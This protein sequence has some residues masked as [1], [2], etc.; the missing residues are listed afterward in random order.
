MAD[1]NPARRRGRRGWP[2]LV[3]GTEAFY[4]EPGSLPEHF[5]PVSYGM[6]MT[7]TQVASARPAG[8]TALDAFEPEAAGGKLDL[9][10]PNVFELDAESFIIPMAACLRGADNPVELLSGEVWRH[11]L[12]P[13]STDITFP[14]RWFEERMIDDG[15]PTLFTDLRPQ[16]VVINFTENAQVTAT[17]TQQAERASVHVLPVETVGGATVGGYQVYLIG[18]PRYDLRDVDAAADTL[19]IHLQVVS[20]DATTITVLAKIGDAS[21]FG[22]TESIIPITAPV[23]GR[24]PTTGELVDSNGSGGLGSGD[25]PLLAYAVVATPAA[26]EAGDEHRADY[27]RPEWVHAPSTSPI[28]RASGA[29]ILLPDRAGNLTDTACV[30]SGSVTITP[31][32]RVVPCAPG[33]WR[34]TARAGRLSVAWQIT[35]EW[36]TIIRDHYRT[37]PPSGQRFGVEVDLQSVGEIATGFRSRV[38][39][40]SRNLVITGP[41]KAVSGDDDR[42]QQWSATAHEASADPDGYVAPVVIEV[43]NT[44]ATLPAPAA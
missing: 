43:D 10:G 36:R 8:S 14:G 28:L 29:R 16:S 9:A 19:N 44:M 31:P 7:P 40:N 42:Q 15:E 25:L 21:S 5:D 34:Q 35:E 1:H 32:F 22:A 38:R 4:L 20:S 2:R 18:L 17:L 24:P 23:D 33:G 39:L 11:R 27:P 6:V 41:T 26:I 37:T 3:G 12:D 13:L 30:A